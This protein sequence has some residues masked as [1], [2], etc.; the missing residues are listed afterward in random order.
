MSYDNEVSL[1]MSGLAIYS[2][3][4]NS[5]SDTG[6]F[7]RKHHIY[8]RPFLLL[9]TNIYYNP[10]GQS[11]KKWLKESNNKRLGNFVVFTTFEEVLEIV[12]EETRAQLLFHLDLFA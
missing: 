12:D 4:Y 7:I 9:G 5:I 1:K 10:A 8:G 3:V 6:L 11:N 2:Y